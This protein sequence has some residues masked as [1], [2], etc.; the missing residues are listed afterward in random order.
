MSTKVCKECLREL[1]ETMF[2]MYR[3]GNRISVCKDCVSHKMR[4]SRLRWQIK[5][6]EWQL[7]DYTTRH[8]LEELANRGVIGKVYV[9]GNTFEL[10]DYNIIKQL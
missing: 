2:K 5:K 1:D 4:L 6:R 10:N 9:D 8:L 7:H 3:T